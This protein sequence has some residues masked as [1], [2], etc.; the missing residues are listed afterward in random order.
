MTSA[1]GGM[2]FVSCPLVLS[3]FPYDM[4]VVVSMTLLSCLTLMS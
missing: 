4:A 1:P 2:T 3:A